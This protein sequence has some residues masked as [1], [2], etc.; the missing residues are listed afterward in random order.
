MSD[1]PIQ[2]PALDA[3]IAKA[4]QEVAKWLY[5]NGLIFEFNRTFL[6]PVGKALRVLVCDD[7]RV[8]FDG[9]TKT[10]DP[11]GI[12]F[13]PEL[14]LEGN[15]KYEKFEKENE[16]RFRAR[17]EKFGF[18]IQPL[19]SL[20][21]P[22]PPELPPEI[23]R[24]V[25][26]FF[27]VNIPAKTETSVTDIKKEQE[28]GSEYPF[29]DEDSLVR[30]AIKPKRIRIEIDYEDVEGKVGTAKID[31]SV[32]E[33]IPWGL[34]VRQSRL[35]P[36][37]FD[38]GGGVKGFAGNRSL[39]QI[40]VVTDK[41]KETISEKEV[42]VNGRASSSTKDRLSYAQ[43]LELAGLPQGSM[44]TMT[45]RSGE[46]AGTLVDGQTVALVGKTVF[47]AINTSNA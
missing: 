34:H 5:D 37:V 43:V 4:D 35:D 30:P 12:E 24:R 17:K 20:E 13:G 23:E 26:L 15:A 32:S 3:K 6:H 18:I 19:S 14:F 27:N 40:T 1:D 22:A 39:L 36:L 16:E 2:S 8:W 38:Q 7:G 11:E 31:R 45:Y 9:I 10:D 25:D 28:R 42:I 44:Y 29:E 21:H 46:G 47:N 41:P 33:D